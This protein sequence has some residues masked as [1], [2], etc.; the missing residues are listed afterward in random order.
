LK[1]VEPKNQS[2]EDEPPEV[3]LKEL[4]P[5]IEYA[6][7]GDNGKWPVIIVKDLSSNEK[8]ALINVLKTRKKAIGW[9]LTDIK[10]IDPEFCSHK[11]LLKIY[12]VI[13]KEVEKLLDAGLIYPISDSPWVSPIHSVPKKGGMTVIKN[14]E[15]ELVPARLV[16][17]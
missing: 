10:G 5:H 16:I 1:V 6:F 2:F 3:E 7:L 9:K 12:D 4:P 11:I 15:N 17:G 8:T 13:K 14:D